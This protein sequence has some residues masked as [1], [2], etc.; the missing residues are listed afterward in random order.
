MNGE[1]AQRVA[2]FV[3]KPDP[4]TA[5]RFIADGFLWNSGIFVWRVRDLLDE[6]AAHTPEIASAIATATSAD[7][8]FARVTPISIDHGVMER[9]ARVLVL[10]GDFAWDDIG[11]WAALRRVRPRDAAGNAVAGPVH[12][13]NSS[14]NVVHA[15]GATIV[16]YGVSDLVV[17]ARNGLTLVTTVEA[18]AD[19]KSLLDA[20]PPEV[21]E[22]A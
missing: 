22:L 5:A 19:L 7:E 9:S 16:L 10:P 17:V 20:L 21:R 13:V 8:F 4:P 18:A 3:E 15:E 14:G 11:T 2:R 12:V 6:I 1:G